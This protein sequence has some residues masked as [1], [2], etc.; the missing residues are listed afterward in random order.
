[1]DGVYSCCDRTDS[2]RISDT[3]VVGITENSQAKFKSDF[4]LSIVENGNRK[5][6]DINQ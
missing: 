5:L 3:V 2:E 4:R 6:E 1:M